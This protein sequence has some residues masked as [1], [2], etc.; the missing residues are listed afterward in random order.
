MEIVENKAVLIRTR[1][2]EKYTVIPRS[3]VVDRWVGGSTVAVYW[4]L[5][6]MRVL[7]N[8]GVKHAPSPIRKNYKWPGR[9]KPMS[10][11]IDTAEFL[12]IHRRALVF[13]E[14]GTGKKL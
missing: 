14:P 7:R 12:T 4:G 9:F 11:Q 10:H 8:L 2:P 6:E 1:N 5:D 3:K 13:N